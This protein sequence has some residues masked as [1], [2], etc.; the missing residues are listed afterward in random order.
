M[1]IGLLSLIVIALAV[2]GYLIGRRIALAKAGGDSRRL[3]SLPGY[4]GQSVFLFTAVPALVLMVGWLLVQPVMIESRVSG[5]ITAAD[6]PDGSNADLVMS[7]VRRISTGLDLVLAQGALSETDLDA[8]RADF[9]DVRGRLAEVGVALGANVK[10]AVFQAAKIYRS[11][12]TT[13]RWL[14][15]GAVLVLALAGM[16][17]ALSRITVEFRARNVT[18][19]FVKTLLIGA[20]LVAILTTVGIVLSLVVETV[21]FFKLYPAKD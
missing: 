11:A 4:Y 15:T 8:M 18:E 10:P 12:A 16:A 5:M 6:I 13:G 19:A 20:S 2:A 3:H 1:S 17:Y 7:D 14:M 9:T 21:H